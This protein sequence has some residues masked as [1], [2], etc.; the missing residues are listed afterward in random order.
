MQRT[1]TVQPPHP[2]LRPGLLAAAVA[3]LLLVACGGTGATSADTGPVTL[4]LGFQ[5]NLTHAPALVG[6]RQGVLASSLG[7]GVILRTSTFN[8]GPDEVEALLSSSI[9]AAYLG[10]NPAIN[11]Y[12]QSHGEAVRIVSGA[13]S[14]GAA[15]VVRGTI[16]APSDLKG[17]TLA[18]PQLGSTQDVALRYWLQQK[19][20]K[21]TTAGGGDVS[22]RPQDNATTLQTFRAGQIDGAWV[23][24]PWASRLVIEGGGHVQVDERSLWPGG[25]FAT[26]VLMVRTDFLR[27]HPTTVRH[28]VEGQVAADDLING[29]AADAQAAANAQLAAITGRPLADAVVEQAWA[30]MTFTVDPLAI[31]LQDA[32]QHAQRVGLL[33]PVNLHGLV[34]VSTL[35]QV[36]AARARPQVSGL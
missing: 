4:R 5:A 30:R 32:A 31:T 7:S 1:T 33:G 14:G 19:G 34:D 22:I 11:A 26:T 18:T 10:P 8:A 23:P 2:P 12:T 15:L 6:V 20:L 25:R 13:T 3:G 27:Q 21:T 9:D 17:R 24:E 35:N 28:L 16:G 29:H 36:L